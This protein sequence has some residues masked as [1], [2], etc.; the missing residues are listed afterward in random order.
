M[1]PAALGAD[2]TER[3]QK[4]QA[5]KKTGLGVI[6]TSQ[7]G[8]AFNNNTTFAGFDDTIKA[9]VIQAFDLVLMRI[10]EQT[11][12]ITGVFR[13]RLNGIQQKDAVHNVEAGARNSYIIT[14]PFYQ[15]M[16][17]LAMDIL[18]DCLDMAKIVYK[19][20]LTGVIILGDKLQK[21]FTAL[22]EHFTFSDHDIHLVPSTKI[23]KDMQQMQ[24]LVF[25]LIKGGMIEPDM[26]VEAMT[27]RSLTELK[28]MVKKSWAKK[29]KENDMLGQLQQK[30][31]EA[32]Q[33]LQQLGQ[34]N[35]QMQSKLES[36]NESKLQL[37]KEKIK[38]DSDIRWFMAQTERTYKTSQIENDSKKVQIELAQIYDGNPYNDQVRIQ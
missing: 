14:K 23:L 1:L 32:Q 24:G 15:Q 6:D 35:Q 33:Q 5:Y 2:L 9:Q 11:S 7:E 31:Q 10:E 29:K 22:P 28:D 13:E 17:T 16:D 25:E 34:Q 20:G 8:R 37:E 36:L 38:A 27:A 12:S 21:T 26:A 3:L 18:R 19:D 30:L 4:W